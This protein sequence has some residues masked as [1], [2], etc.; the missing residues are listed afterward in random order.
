MAT[1]LPSERDTRTAPRPTA[2][3]V[4]VGSGGSFIGLLIL[5]HV[6]ESD[7]DPSWRMISEYEIG[8]YGWVM[9]AA[10]LAFAASCVAVQRTLAGHL[11]SRGGRIGGGFLLVTAAGLAM[12]GLFTSDPITA[13]HDQLTTHGNLHGLGFML[14]CPA[15]MI[16]VTLVNRAVRRNPAWVHVARRVRWATRA[17]WASLVL[18]V[19]SMGVFFDGGFGPDVK[20]GWPNRILVLSWAAWVIVVARSA[21]E[22]NA[23]EHRDTRTALAP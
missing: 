8:R 16:A 3:M 1:T 6:V 5:L 15:F 21:T 2:A 10:F 18:F 17:V 13:T 23:N 22:V 7:F 9:S 14:G 12:G 20:I 19:G 4:A 11:S